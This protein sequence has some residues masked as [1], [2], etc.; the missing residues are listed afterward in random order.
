[1]GGSTKSIQP[2][3]H[4]GF[5][6]SAL[7]V[8]VCALAGC[9][10]GTPLAPETA[11]PA[12]DAIA[13]WSAAGD[14]QTFDTKTL[15][16]YID[17]QA[18]YFFT[19]GFEALA[20]R[21]YSDGQGVEISVEVWR[22]TTAEDA[23]G[24]FSGTDPHQ[25][26]AVADAADAWL[27]T[28]SRVSFWQDRFFVAVGSS[29]PVEDAVL[30]RFADGVSRALPKGG[31]PPALIRRLP[32]DPQPKRL[33][34][35]FRSEMAIQNDLWLGGKE[36]LGLTPQAAGILAIYDFESGPVKL[37][38]LQYPDDATPGAAL[39]ALAGGGIKTFVAARSEGVRLGVV[40]GKIDKAAADALLAAIDWR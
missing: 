30:L 28:G 6:F 40:F 29:T 8:C 1:M 38:L 35:F 4:P 33:P 19:Y 9:A 25:T 39:N 17:G 15:F 10:S 37:I 21:R 24:L 31:S 22:T 36:L 16:R 11:L 27:E 34:I 12:S 5:L 14:V 32:A 18:E 2:R 3:V 23:Y 7:A 26:A 20:V 13:G